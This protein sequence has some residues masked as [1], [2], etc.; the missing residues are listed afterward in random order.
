VLF[1]APEERRS[2][3]AGSKLV[4][5]S[6]AVPAPG[7]AEL[8]RVVERG[9]QEIVGRV[10]FTAFPDRVALR[11]ARLGD[12]VDGWMTLDENGREAQ[13]VLSEGLGP[14]A[15]SRALA[16]QLGHVVG[17]SMPHVD[18]WWAEATARWL[19]QRIVP[20]ALENALTLGTRLRK[21][22]VAID[23]AGGGALTWLRFLTVRFGDDTVRQIWDEASLEEAGDA[24][25]AT[26]SVLADRGHVLEDELEAHAAWQVSEWRRQALAGNGVAPLRFAA[27]HAEFPVAGRIDD[28]APGRLGTTYLRFLAADVAGA[29]RVELETEPGA[30]VAASAIL[31]ADGDWMPSGRVGFRRV[32]IDRL[33]LT[34]PASDVGELIVAL[35]NLGSPDPTPFSWN[36]SLED[37]FPYVLDDLRAEVQSDAVRLTWVTTEE[38]GVSSWSVLR[39]GAPGES[40]TVLTGVPMPALVELGLGDE[41]AS[42]GF[43]DHA[44]EAG[45]TYYYLVRAM[46][47]DGLPAS[48]HIVTVTLR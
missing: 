46:T 43:V 25:Q 5:V 22:D 47:V 23:E 31:I 21:P 14:R 16:H 34:V 17:E 13:I 40:F 36:A 37:R 29:V 11:F 24:V 42:Y 2:V 15:L 35:T 12:G 1:F 18:R 30:P 10:G 20:D 45:Q 27:D 19:E 39:S 48:S 33:E 28:G 9:Y 26:R 3:A 6:G 8:A 38:R 7:S 41:G 44:V 32:A 4:L